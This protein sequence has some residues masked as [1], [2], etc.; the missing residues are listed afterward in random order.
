MVEEMKRDCGKDIIK[1]QHIIYY[2]P[3]RNIDE[4]VQD[5]HNLEQ[6]FAYQLNTRKDNCFSHLN[7]YLL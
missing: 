1:C 4:Q 6:D 5:I 7:V 2:Y 3:I